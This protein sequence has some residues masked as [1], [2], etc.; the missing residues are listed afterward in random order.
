MEVKQFK[1]GIWTNKVDVRNFVVNNI[2]PYYGT[3]HFL[4]G[5]SDRT[6]KLWEICKEATKQERK[7]NGVRAVDTETISTISAFNAGYIDKE[8]EV[9][10]GLQ[11]D[12]LLKRTMKPFGGFK[13]VQKALSEHGLNL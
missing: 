1:T 12:E 6:Q 7:S 11:T 9:I 13:V 4:V 8:N 5:P 3:H 2:T 10:V